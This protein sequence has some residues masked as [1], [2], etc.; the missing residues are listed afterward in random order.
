LLAAVA[1]TGLLC[2]ENTPESD[3]AW[4][5]VDEAL[6]ALNRP[7]DHPPQ[8]QEE[9]MAYVK[10]LISTADDAA[11][12]FTD[13]FP[14]DPRR[15]KIRMFDAMT[16]SAREQL[17]LPSHGD[18]K[19]IVNEVVKA[20]DADAQ[21]KGEADGILVLIAGAELDEGHGTAE[22]WLD[23]ANEHLKKYP[24]AKLNREIKS[25]IEGLKV[26]AELQ[27]KPLDLKFKSL[28]GREVDLSQMRGKV[29]L[30]DFWATWCG[31][32]VGEVPNVVKTYEKLH[33]KGFEIVG[34]SLDQDQSKL[35]SFTK[36]N[37]MTWPQYFDGKG[38]EN[39]FA[40]RF[41]IHSIPAMWLV[42][43]KGMLIT[44]NARAHLE[45]LVEKHLAE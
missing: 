22:K 38:W 18:I 3:A 2:A 21:N 27:S 12:A 30:V 23:Q 42:N 14:N 11:K 8:S 28:D 5:N 16:A 26:L 41:G 43:K 40:D 45:E 32:C 39:Q 34:I 10:K 15:W 17:G 13:K 20:P 1:L 9:M 44:N 29:V 7:P 37:K 36:E 33:E 19:T 6:N 35:E 4:K 24:D 25:K 31:P